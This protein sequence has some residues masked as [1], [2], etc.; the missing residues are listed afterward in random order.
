MKVLILTCKTGQGHNSSATAIK[1]AFDHRG[2]ECDIVDNVA[3]MSKIGAKLMDDL[4]TGIYLHMPKFFDRGYS[5]S[6]FKIG[7][8]S[9]ARLFA[10]VLNMFSRGLRKH[11]AKNGYT[12][13]ITVHLLSAVMI[14]EMNSKKPLRTHTSFLSTDYTLLPFISGTA[15]DM[16][17]LPHR[18]L[19]KLFS[20]K[21]ISEE[22]HRDT[23]IPVR[24][25]FL[26]CDLTKSD[27]RAA[28]NIPNDAKVVFI[29]GGS[30]GCGP[31]EELVESIAS[32]E[33]DKLR[34]LVSCG[35]NKQ[36][37][38]SLAKK[39][40]NRINAFSYSNEIPTIMRAL[41]VF[42]TKPGGVSITEAAVMAAP[43][44]LLN[45]IGGCETPNYNFFTSHGFALGAKDIAEVAQ[46]CKSLL[47]ADQ[48]LQERCEMLRRE[49]GRNS[50]DE[51]ARAIIESE[52]TD[53]AMV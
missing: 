3:L 41:D 1:Q 27:A 32:I 22:K 52:S 35:T 53:L 24:S 30:M 25:D 17:F 44:V 5:M 26:C 40:D 18:D 19:G 46:I 39:S 28:L 15:L 2:I 7:H 29:M 47:T 12:H 20:E 11:I 21:G 8:F 49:F 13:V 38:K 23:G 34:I 36:L 42:V 33:D 6:E 31:I 16:Y 48:D 9:S 10:K 4:F 14:S 37:L 51:I 43:M 50:A 45:A